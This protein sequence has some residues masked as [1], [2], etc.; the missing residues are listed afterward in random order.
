M[1]V[2][3][4][5]QAPRRRAVGRCLFQLSYVAGYGH[6]SATLF[7]RSEPHRRTLLLTRNW[8]CAIF[9]RMLWLPSFRQAGSVAGEYVQIRKSCGSSISRD[10]FAWRRV[11][12][13]SGDRD[14]EFVIGS[15]RLTRT[16]FLRPLTRCVVAGAVKHWSMSTR[17]TLLGPVRQQCALHPRRALRRG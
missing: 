8:T 2:K 17:G 7:V 4:D 12:S 1:I 9:Y 15:I 14:P 11:G 3:D 5:A 13:T 16:A 10:L 6:A